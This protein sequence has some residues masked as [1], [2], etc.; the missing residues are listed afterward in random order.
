MNI[1]SNVT[2]KFRLLR[3]SYLRDLD[4]KSD[5]LPIELIGWAEQLEVSISGLC[6]LEGKA[7]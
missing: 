7:H 5:A 1:R 3:G 6:I 4:Y 2:E